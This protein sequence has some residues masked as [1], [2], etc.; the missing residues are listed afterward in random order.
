MNI[1]VGTDLVEIKQIEKAM[2]RPAFLTKVFGQR[3]LA[4]L[5]K[6]GC[7]VQ[8]AAAA[9]AGKEAFSKAL[10]TGIRGFSLKE[11]EVLHLPSGKPYFYL[12][13]AAK[14]LAE[15]LRLDISI[16]HTAQY[17]SATVVAYGP[18]SQERI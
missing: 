12:S 11:V 4:E 14:E 3:E 7:P 5:E 15:G 18:E 6:R 13:G 1:T 16:T 2:E 17:A 8:S 10:G 9:F